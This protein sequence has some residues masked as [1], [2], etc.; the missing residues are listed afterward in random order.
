MNTEHDIILFDGDC[1][2]CTGWVLWVIKRD[3]KDRY[4]FSALQTTAAQQL[5]SRQNLKWEGMESVI[6]ISNGI[7]YSKSDAA[8]RIASGLGGIYKAASVCF[9][10]PGGVRNFVYDFIAKRR[11]SW[12]GKRDQCF[13]PDEKLKGRFL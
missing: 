4:R 6:L 3:K 1:N 8:L 12:F 7:V 13:V 9:I 2:F 10:F 5:I 11:Y